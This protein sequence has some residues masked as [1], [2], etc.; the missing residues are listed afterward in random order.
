MIKNKHLLLLILLSFFVLFFALPVVAQAKEE[1]DHSGMKKSGSHEH[2]EMPQDDQSVGLDEKIGSSIPLD[3]TF[4]DEAGQ[5]V[6]LRQLITGPTIIAPVYFRCPNVC[7]FLQ[8]DL[9]RVLPA[10]RRQPGSDY[11]V[12]SFSF[13]ETESPELAVKSKEMYLKAMQSEFPSAAWRFLTGDKEAIMQLTS[14]AGYR[15]RKM[16]D[17]QFLHPVVVFVVDAK[18][19]IVRYLHGTRFLPK[20]LTLALVEASAGRLGTTIRKMVQFCFSYDAENKT[21]V[22]N[23]LRI[24]GSVVL[25]TLVAFMVFLLFG[26]KKKKREY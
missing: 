12:I 2:Q 21:Y 22:F 16:P 9:A 15:F 10:I 24:S 8:S 1:M 20:D 18:G 19:T 17:G 6:S 7:N 13:D 14:A 11:K 26:G 4:L 5:P 3:L 23:L 25:L